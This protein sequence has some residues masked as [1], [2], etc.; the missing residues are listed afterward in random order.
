MTGNLQSLQAFADLISARPA[1]IWDSAGHRATE[2]NA[3]AAALFGFGEIAAFEAHRFDAGSR[4]A[5]QCDA[6]A[7]SQIRRRQPG[8]ERIRVIQGVRDFVVTVQCTARADGTMAFQALD[9]GPFRIPPVARR[10]A[11]AAEGLPDEVT[12]TDRF[13]G[14]LGGRRTDSDDLGDIARDF[15]GSGD[16]SA[17]TGGWELT[18]LDAGDAVIIAARRGQRA[19]PA[20]RTA[21]LSIVRTLPV[22]PAANDRTRTEEGGDPLFGL[23]YRLLIDLDGV[24]SDADPALSA[25]LGYHGD[26]IA[27]VDLNHVCE[28]RDDALAN[29]LAAG[30]AFRDVPAVWTGPASTRG[31]IFSGAPVYDEDLE[32]AGYRAHATGGV[33]IS[34][35]TSAEREVPVAAADE[36]FIAAARAILADE[37]LGDDFDDEEE[38]APPAKTDDQRAQLL[39]HEAKAFQEIGRALTGDDTAA[40]DTEANGAGLEDSGPDEPSTAEAAEAEDISE[41]APQLPE[42]AEQQRDEPASADADIAASGEDTQSL[43]G[44]GDQAVTDDDGRLIDEVSDGII[45]FRDESILQANRPLLQMFGY[46]DIA[47]IEQAGGVGALF[48][49]RLDL[50]AESG[51][52][53]V[54][55]TRSGDSFAIDARLRRITSGGNAAMAY[56]VRPIV[57]AAA[58][59]AKPEPA[60]R[61]VDADAEIA[62]L[63]AI[64]DTATEGVVV[65]DS[66]GRIERLNQSAEALFGHDSSAVS[67]KAFTTLIAPES[68][69]SVQD[70]IDGLKRNGV[71]SILNDGREITGRVAQG[72]A[73]PL[74]LTMGRLGEG[75]Q[76]KFCAVIRDITQ[77]KKAESEL[78]EARRK[79]ETL[80]AQKSEFL[81]KISHEIR[82]PLN[83][84][85]GFS[86]VMIEERFGPIG[87]ERYRGYMHD[88]RTSGDHVLS[89]INDLLDLSKIEAGHMELDFGSVLLNDVVEQSVAIMQPQANKERIL[90][91]TNLTHDLPP[92]VADQRS[93]RQVLLNLLSNAVKFTPPGG[94]IIVS[95]IHTADGDVLL[96]VRDTGVGMNETD[97]RTAMEPFR[98]VGQN[99]L[100]T[101]VGT[102]LGLPLTKALVEANRASFGIESKVDHGTLIEVSFPQNRVLAE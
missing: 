50:A 33:E 2:A 87:N 41:V 15:A 3:S 42:M 13:G 58:P 100:N 21:P 56:F 69:D 52:R 99:R 29:A 24:V 27:G 93:M 98:Q 91:R 22:R 12:L 60:D 8:I 62:E 82:T 39:P 80:S 26:D 47:G 70:Y 36:A 57:E 81:A 64:L 35:D 75:P 31:F 19:E 46:A 67:G 4:L 88:I 17:V 44:G 63:R 10:I 45:V 92:V 11:M 43:P 83:A 89:L 76:A 16:K 14:V 78:V 51:R 25:L 66:E 37:D 96:R 49:E 73:L 54:G 48:A 20:A 102:G 55:V 72:G 1:W 101:K 97:I 79:A 30:T 6:I 77:W 71:A 32:L 84:I 53:L 61:Q 7:G 34:D 65:L 85:I 95:T 86:E 74:F 90:I 94:Q 59:E 5:R 28:T 68:R 40:E 38:I 23:R 18:R 9:T